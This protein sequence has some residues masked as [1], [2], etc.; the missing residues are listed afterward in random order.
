MKILSLKDRKKGL[1][2]VLLEDRTELLLD[3]ETVILNSLAPGANIGDPDALLYESD[4]KRAKSRALWYLSRGD[5]S[6]KKLRE[7]LT[8]GGFM[9]GAVNDAVQRMKELD[10]I[11]DER[12]AKRVSEYLTEQ[13][14]SKREI[15]YKLMNKGIP[16]SVAR[17]TA[18]ET[19]SDE[20]EKLG[21]L[22]K[23][24]YASKLTCEEGVKKVF[25]ALIR[26]GYSYSDVRDALKAYSEEL[27]NEEF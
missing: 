22:I 9:P 1:T 21:K 26:K 6:E 3:T 15:V 18:E 8:L 19:E 2:Q 11:N 20:T 16:S 5:L 25:A 27:E 7:K 23:T 12:F 17:Q 4:L 10:L 24:K 13:G 14:A